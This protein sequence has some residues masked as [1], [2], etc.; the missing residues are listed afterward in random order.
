MHIHTHV[1]GLFQSDS[2]QL[3]GDCQPC[4]CKGSPINSLL[5]K[6]SVMLKD[7]LLKKVMLKNSV[8]LM[9]K[10]AFKL[11]VIR[12]MDC[13]TYAEPEDVK[14]RCRRVSDVRNSIVQTV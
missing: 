2:G 10:Y 12:G 9:E 5:E 4:S 7:S 13:L 6:N 14:L 11:L 8:M 3:L 1:P